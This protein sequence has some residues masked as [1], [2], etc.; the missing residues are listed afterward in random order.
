MNEQL[1]VEHFIFGFHIRVNKISDLELDDK[2]K[3]HLL[4]RQVASYS[5]NKMLLLVLIVA[6]TMLIASAHPC[7]K[8]T[9]TVPIHKQLNSMGAMVGKFINRGQH[10]GFRRC[11]GHEYIGCSTHGGIYGMIPTFNAFRTSLNNNVPNVFVDSGSFS[12]VFRRNTPC[13]T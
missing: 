11:G 6:A 12:I 9:R 2:L 7:T 3:G 8:S 1:R 5:K 4:L 10:R 13:F